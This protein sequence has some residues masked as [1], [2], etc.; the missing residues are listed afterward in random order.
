LSVNALKTFGC[1]QSCEGP[2]LGG[3][4]ST[5]DHKFASGGWPRTGATR[6]ST[7]IAKKLQANCLSTIVWLLVVE[8]GL[9]QSYRTAGAGH[10]VE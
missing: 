2:R 7:A 10:G 8:F 9:L 4:C 1:T 5:C 6:L 3:T